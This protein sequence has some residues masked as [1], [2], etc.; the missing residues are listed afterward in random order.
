MRVYR[1]PHSWTSAEHQNILVILVRQYR[2]NPTPAGRE[3]ITRLMRRS[4]VKTCGNLGQ[5]I[6]LLLWLDDVPPGSSGWHARCPAC[7]GDG[8]TLRFRQ[9]RHGYITMRCRRGCRTPSIWAAL[10]R[11]GY[12]D[13]A[14][15]TI[16]SELKAS[17]AFAPRG[18]RR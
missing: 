14:G 9:N 16:A 13:G 5:V 8:L 1:R 6:T 2:R 17:D 15:P 7:C 3:E 12:V 10:R 4:G 11:M 18:S